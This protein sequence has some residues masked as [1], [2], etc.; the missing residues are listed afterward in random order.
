MRDLHT[1]AHTYTIDSMSD[2]KKQLIR[3]GIIIGA[4]ILL[5]GVFAYLLRANISHQSDVIGGLKE[6]RA[7]AS[8]SSKNLA[9][10][11]TDWGTVQPY[12]STVATLVPTKDTVVLFSKNLQTL[13]QQ[14]QLN[15]NFSFQNDTS[16]SGSQVSSVQ[17][18]ATIEGDMAHIFSFLQS[19][20]DQYFAFRIASLDIT[21]ENKGNNVRVFFTGSVYYH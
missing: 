14:Q 5:F 6:Q 11:I 10:L 13:A 1:D 17:Y 21:N 9:N 3:Q 2:F 7:Q 15:L 18:T 19:V 4:L 20:Q 8:Q 12:Q 16:G